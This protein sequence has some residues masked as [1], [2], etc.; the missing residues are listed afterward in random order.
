MLFNI[1]IQMELNLHRKKFK[2][3][4]SWLVLI[5]H[6]SVEPKFLK[7]MIYP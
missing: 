2:N 3:S 4:I 7:K 1:F 6:T 5:V